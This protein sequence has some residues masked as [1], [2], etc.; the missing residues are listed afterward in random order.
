[1][2]SGSRDGH[3][4]WWERSTKER[5]W[6]PLL[7]VNITGG[8]RV[9]FTWKHSPYKHPDTT[10]Y[11]NHSTVDWRTF[12]ILRGENSRISFR[13]AVVCSAQVCDTSVPLWLVHYS[14]ERN[15]CRGVLVRLC[16]IGY[17]RSVAFGKLNFSLPSW[18]P[19]G[20]T[21]ETG[22]FCTVY[23]IMA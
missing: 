10:L 14:Q 11:D 4:A 9:A 8:R 20:L 13:S 16:R 22:R 23:A 21:E 19:R 5:G 15:Q 6:F 7:E 1:M 18:S 12:R 2:T 3:V 17:W